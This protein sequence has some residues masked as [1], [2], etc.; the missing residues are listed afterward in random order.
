MKKKLKKIL[1]SYQT[2][3]ILLI[4]LIV[5]LI[6]YTNYLVKNNDTYLF[7][8]N[9][10][11]VDIYNGVISL[12]YDINVFV[13]SDINYLKEDIKVSKYKIGYYVKINDTYKEF[14]VKEDIDEEGFSLKN[15]IES[16]SSYNLTELTKNKNYFSKEKIKALED[17]LYFIIEAQ[18]EKKETIYNKTDILL[19][20]VS[21]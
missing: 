3:L 21:K 15:T 1:K 6:I 4:I 20:K 7:N 10:E 11:Y 9:D 18:T 14:I 8:A 19:S 13:G 2:I 16:I 17:G 5:T 12:N